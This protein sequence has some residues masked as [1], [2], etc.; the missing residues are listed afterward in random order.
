MLF[1]SVDRPLPAQLSG[2]TKLELTAT[3]FRL[4]RAVTQVEDASKSEQATA[5]LG[6][7]NLRTHMRCLQRESA[8]LLVD[9]HPL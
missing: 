1:G 6:S 3:G 9:D 7:A 5:T 4:E 8:I 2:V